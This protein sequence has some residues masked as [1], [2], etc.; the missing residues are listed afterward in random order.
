MQE[1]IKTWT[2]A[3]SAVVRHLGQLS[4]WSGFA[5][6]C[7]VS[8]NVLARYLFGFG[9]VDLQ[10]AEWH[11]LAVAALMGMSYGLNQGAEVRV[12]ILYA[13]MPPQLQAAIDL[14]ASVLLAAIALIIAWLSIA[15]VQSS[16]MINEGSP[17]PGGLGYRYLLKAF[18]PLAFLML[19]VQAVAMIGDAALKLFFPADLPQ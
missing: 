4:A 15:Y 6:V 2:H 12:D 11:L 5:L 1:V 17:D 3:A 13:R 7:V 14:V 16:Y 10:E 8:F 9:R 18:I 19:S